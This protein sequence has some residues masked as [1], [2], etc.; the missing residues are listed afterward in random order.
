MQQEQ[1]M[2]TAQRRI[3]EA[4]VEACCN[5]GCD[6]LNATDLWL[7]VEDAWP[8]VYPKPLPVTVTISPGTRVKIANNEPSEAAGVTL[9]RSVAQGPASVAGVGDELHI[10]LG[11]FHVTIDLGEIAP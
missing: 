9:L 2:T 3:R 8:R 5:E 1:E 10:W 6:P 7:G 4:F 11:H